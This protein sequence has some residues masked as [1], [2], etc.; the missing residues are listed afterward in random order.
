MV[1]IDDDYI[2]STITDMQNKLITN[3]QEYQTIKTILNNLQTI[4][5]VEVSDP[6]ESDANQTKKVMPT[7]PILRIEMTEDRRHEIYDKIVSDVS[8]I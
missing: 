3:R 1:E 6:V 4:T 8:Q 7:D 5:L 2:E